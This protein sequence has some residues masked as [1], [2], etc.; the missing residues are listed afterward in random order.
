MDATPFLLYLEVF[1]KNLKTKKISGFFQNSELVDKTWPEFAKKLAKSNVFSKFVDLQPINRVAM[2]LR[3]GDYSDDP[4][5]KSYYGL[6]KASY[7]VL[8]YEELN[9]NISNKLEVLVVTDDVE[10]AKKTINNENCNTLVTYV[11]NKS[12]IDDLFEISRSS[13][14]V[15]SNSTF[16]WWGAWFAHKSH[17]AKIVYPR[18]WFADNSNPDL[19]IYFSSWTAKKRDFF[20]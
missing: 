11:S 17:G 19:P 10:K 6:T 9:K 1:M 15:M 16:S 8:A 7:Y 20:I 13:H 2:H 5:T 14:V 3:F 18:P 4:N 12:A